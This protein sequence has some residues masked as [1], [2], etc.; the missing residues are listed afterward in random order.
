[1]V[2]NDAHG[3]L[4]RDYR[5]VEVAGAATVASDPGVWYYLHATY[6]VVLVAGGIA[7]VLGTWLSRPGGD[8]S[9]GQALALAVGSTPPTGALVARTLRVGPLP[10]VDFTPLALSVTGVAFGYAFVRL[11]LFGFSPAA[12]RLGRRAAIDDV[13]VGIVV[14]D[15]DDRVVEL[16]ATAESTPTSRSSRSGPPPPRRSSTDSWTTTGRSLATKPISKVR[17]ACR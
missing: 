1:V 11:E 12:A 15:A 14:V 17:C 5:L 3:L 16:N 2:T 9:R 6:G 8:A 13:G 7:L 4:W 10:T